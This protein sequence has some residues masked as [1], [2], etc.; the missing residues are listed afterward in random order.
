MLT[1]C[2]CDGNFHV[3]QLKAVERGTCITCLLMVF[4]M[5]TNGT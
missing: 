2:T 3:C 4:E 5:G 1:N